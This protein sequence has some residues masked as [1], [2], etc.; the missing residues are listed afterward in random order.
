MSVSVW[1][2]ALVLDRTHSLPPARGL[3]AIVRMVV[4]AQNR[5]S[6]DL[7]S[8]RGDARSHKSVHTYT[9]TRLGKLSHY[10]RALV[11][12]KGC[13]EPAHLR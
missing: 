8:S 1:S 7:C 11:F 12:Y 13:W 6:I 4:T 9:S 2:L 5:T 10:P 3:A